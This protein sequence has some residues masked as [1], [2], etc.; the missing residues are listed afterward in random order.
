MWKTHVFIE[1]FGISGKHSIKAKS[2]VMKKTE[3]AIG[4]KKLDNN[5]VYFK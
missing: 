3:F 1:K 2:M 4:K 5:A